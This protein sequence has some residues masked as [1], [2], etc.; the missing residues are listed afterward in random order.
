MFWVEFCHTL[1]SV[2]MLKSCVLGILHQWLSP[3]TENSHL[4]GVPV[5]GQLWA[6]LI[7]VQLE[8]HVGRAH[9]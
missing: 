9:I 5:R 1:P 7:E 2:Q 3:I 8:S 4:T 6:V